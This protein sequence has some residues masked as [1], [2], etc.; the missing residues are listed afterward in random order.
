[1]KMELATR[2]VPEQL[3]S[4]EHVGFGKSVSFGW[5]SD[6]FGTGGVLGD[7]RG[8]TAEQGKAAFEAAIE[9]GTAAMRE[10]A[11]FDPRG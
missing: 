5:L 8:A 4:Y 1:V 11:R 10:I 2:A 6:D 3:T 9:H 7:P